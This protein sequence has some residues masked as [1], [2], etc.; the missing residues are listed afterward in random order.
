MPLVEVS[1]VHG[2]EPDQIRALISAV[3]T[4]V[5]QT[6]AAPQPSIRVLVREIPETHWAAGDKTMAERRDTQ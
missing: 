2:R 6:L 4:A 3:T 1:I 5:A